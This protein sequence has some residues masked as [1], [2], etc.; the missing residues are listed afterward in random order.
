MFREVRPALP[1][2]RPNPVG[3]IRTMRPN[4][5]GCSA[6][7]TT[8]Y[9]PGSESATTSTEV[10]PGCSAATRMRSSCSP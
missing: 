4:R 5:C 1:L 3:L 8:T 9:C 10:S 7:A 2:K 6:A